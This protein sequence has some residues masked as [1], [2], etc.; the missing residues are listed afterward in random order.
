MIPEKTSCIELAKAT[1]APFASV[2][3]LLS[4]PAKL[5]DYVN[6]TAKP[7]IEII[8]IVVKAVSIFKGCNKN[9]IM[10]ETKIIQLPLII[11]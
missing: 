7:I 9:R 4:I 10:P 6:P 2:G 5:F 3:T 1:P 8:I 11:G